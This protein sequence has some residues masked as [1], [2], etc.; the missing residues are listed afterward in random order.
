MA[1]TVTTNMTE[2]KFPTLVPT[3]T[4]NQVRAKREEY[5]PFFS[6]WMTLGDFQFHFQKKKWKAGLGAETAPLDLQ[7][8]DPVAVDTIPMQQVFICICMRERERERCTHTCAVLWRRGRC[9][10]LGNNSAVFASS[11]SL[12][13]THTHTHTHKMHMCIQTCVCV[14]AR[15]RPQTLNPRSAQCVHVHGQ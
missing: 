14:R 15:P 4:T 11:L 1:A 7:M 6:S 5:S 12:T 10:V 2:A 3:H 8:E 13:H 9:L